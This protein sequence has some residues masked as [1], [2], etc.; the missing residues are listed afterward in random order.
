[1]LVQAIP[2]EV[3][4]GFHLM[5][6]IHATSGAAPA[7]WVMRTDQADVLFRWAGPP[8]SAYSLADAADRR[9]ATCGGTSTSTPTVPL[10][11]SE[12]GR[13]VHRRVRRGARR[14]RDRGREDSA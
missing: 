10:P 4:D 13:Q 7:T 2:A 3:L 6:S 12:G 11:D 1:M 5:A 8:C 14:G 9:P